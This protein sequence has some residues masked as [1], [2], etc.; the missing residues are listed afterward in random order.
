MFRLFQ[1]APH[2]ELRAAGQLGL[3]LAHAARQAP[4]TVL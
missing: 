2:E 3:L 1:H 4:R